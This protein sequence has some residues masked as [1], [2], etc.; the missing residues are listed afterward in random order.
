MD[1]IW[2]TIR[3]YASL[4]ASMSKHFNKVT[5]ILGFGAL[6]LY[7]GL[8]VHFCFFFSLIKFLLLKKKKKLLHL[9]KLL[10]SSLYFNIL[11]FVCLE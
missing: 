3:L 10:P 11:L 7:D 9:Q 5:R 1:A 6:L 2:V 4:W 8:L